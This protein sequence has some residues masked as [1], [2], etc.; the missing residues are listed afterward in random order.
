MDTKEKESITLPIEWHIP[1]G[2]KSQFA[3]NLV[4]QHTDQ[5]FI[6]SFFEIEKPVLLG[7]PDEVKS[8]LEVIGK[9]RANCVARIIVTPKRM[10]EFIKAMQTNL[11]KF[12]SR[13]EKKEED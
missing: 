2:L 12:H 9:M 6:I 10:E 5:E 11:D 13:T 3:T 4:I 8:K 1:E 7:S